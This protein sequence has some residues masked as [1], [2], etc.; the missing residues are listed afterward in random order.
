MY[1]YLWGN[2]PSPNYPADTSEI[3][4]YDTIFTTQILEKSCFRLR[5]AFSPG[6]FRKALEDSVVK[7]ILESKQL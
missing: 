1:K 4:L 2:T 6:V 3:L 5:E 7:H